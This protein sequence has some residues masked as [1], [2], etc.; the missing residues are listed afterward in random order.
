MAKI[1]FIVFLLL[2]FFCY[3]DEKIEI[4]ADQFTYDKDNTRIYATGNVEIIDKE[5]KLYANKVFVNNKSKVLSARENI[6]VFNT[7]GTIL[8]ADKIV[9]DHNLENALIENIGTVEFNIRVESVQKER[10]EFI[11]KPNDKVVVKLYRAEILYFDSLTLDKAEA[12][13]IYTINENELPP[14]P[15]PV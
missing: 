8:K 14:P 12:K 10:R 15:P 6:K 13:I 3:A 7:D 11:I 9:A 2:N 5:F 4:N 1:A